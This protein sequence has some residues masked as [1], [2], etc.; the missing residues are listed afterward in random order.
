MS[1]IQKTLDSLQPYVHSIRFVK[2]LPVVDMILTEGW[3]VLEDANITKVKGDDSLNYHMI[4]SDKPGY[5]L[6]ELLAYVERTVKANLD[7][8]KKHD[9]L[10]AKVNEL[11]EIF[12]KN[13]LT[14]LQH[15]KFTFGE[16]DL[17]PSMADIDDDEFGLND[18][19]VI[20]KVVEPE[21]P[22]IPEVEEI[23]ST[24]HNQP[25]T[26]LDENKQPIEL[27]E[28]EKEILEEEA[29]AEKNRKMMAAKKAAAATNNISKKVELPPKRKIEMAINERDYESDCECGPNDACEKC[30]DKKDY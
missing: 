21:Q 23:E 20:N 29:R 16:D 17:M 10:K 3:T 14:K 5:G 22:E 2:G 19:P 30:I 13:S 12:K 11:K 9:L 15:L 26:Y 25:I 24:P 8:E 7:R 6:D 18:K 4:F 27:T 1:N 28:E